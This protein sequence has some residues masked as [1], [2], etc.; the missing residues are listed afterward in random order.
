MAWISSPTQVVAQ[1]VPDAT[2]PNPSVVQLQGTTNRIVGGTQAGAN[3]FHSFK[4]F[5]VSTG[6]VAYFD[7]NPAIANIFA[8]ITGSKPSSVNG[9]IQANGSANLFLLNPNGIL[10]GPNAQLNL[11][12]AFLATTANSILF[13]DGKVFSATP[14]SQSAPLL[15]INRPL[16]LIFNNNPGPITQRSRLGLKV[17]PGKTLSLLGGN[18]NLEG[19]NLTAPGGRIE[20]GSLSS[21]QQVRFKYSPGKPHLWGINYDNAFSFQDIDIANLA[22]VDA[23]GIG[24]GDIQVQG[25]R[26]RLTD[27]GRLQSINRGDLDGGTITVNATDSLDLLGNTDITSPVDIF[28]AQRGFLLP[29]K[30]TIFSTTLGKGR[31]NA[32]V[33][34]TRHL[35]LTDG[36]DI[37]AATDGLG[38]GGNLIINA[39]DS[40]NLRGETVL[41]RFNPKESP[42]TETNTRNFLIDQAKVS[43]INARSAFIDKNGSSSGNILLRT[44]HLTLQDGASIA[45]GSNAGPGGSIRIDASGTVEI[46]G[47]TKSGLSSSNIVSASVS[48]NNAL[49]TVINAKRLSIREGGILASST[50]GAGDAGNILITASE[51]VEVEGTIR[52]G[53]FPSQINSGTFKSGNSGDIQIKTADLKVVDGAAIRLN[54][55]SL[56]KTG[57][58]QVNANRVLLDNRGSITSNAKN[59]PAGN[60]NFD[61][62]LLILKN[63]SNITTNAL[64][65]AGGNITIKAD[66]IIALPKDGDS[67]ITANALNGS[68]GKI[69]ITT[70]GLFGIAVRDRPTALNDITAISQNNPQLNGVVTINTPGVDP[71]NNLSEQ[72]DIIEP[73]QKLERGCQAKDIN[74]KSRFTLVGRGGLPSSPNE[75]LTSVAL[76]QDLRAT[77]LPS[78]KNVSSKPQDSIPVPSLSPESSS[79]GQVEA[80]GWA[81]D[82]QGRIYLT[83]QRYTMA[84]APLPATPSC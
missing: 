46:F 39:T 41:L 22:I 6:T 73:P 17:Q 80:Q 49:D 65:E 66:L 56:G 37:T 28:F 58:L 63:G 34:N 62:Q 61:T 20:L 69:T 3:L 74:N 83:T 36:A 53:L 5:D 29:Q 10:F 8:R 57:S 43:Q 72:P 84:T 24:T 71:S 26:V 16:G 81:K 14:S 18:V 12:G 70:Q 19:G 2:L 45:A 38:R 54:S 55:E 35:R 7:Q 9:L 79:I 23:S 21:N 77:R 78:S 82:R 67:N 44:G 31:S 51:A 40:V 60:L 25:R 1:I 59:S 68:G 47:S 76:W 64:N 75:S 50:F 13:P 48:N 52:T 30:T 27:G 33:I 15:S 4:Q 11:G 32:I 42:F